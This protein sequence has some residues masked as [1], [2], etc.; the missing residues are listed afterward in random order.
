MLFAFVEEIYGLVVEFGSDSTR[1][2]FIGDDRPR[3]VIPSAYA[4]PSGRAGDLNLLG[5]GVE[6][7]VRVLEH[8]EIKDWEG[9]EFLWDEGVRRRL[10]LGLEDDLPP[11]ILVESPVLLS[12]SSRERLCQV[13]F[14]KFKVPALFMGKAPVLTVFESGRHTGLVVDI[15]AGSVSVTPVYDGYVLKNS[16]VVQRGFGSDWLREQLRMA[17]EIDLKID[18]EREL[19]AASEIRTKQPVG[20]TEPSNYELAADCDSLSASYLAYHRGR[21]LDELKESVVQ[22][23]EISFNVNDLALRPPK[24]FEFPTGYNRNFVLER[25]RIGELLFDPSKRYKASCDSVSSG[26]DSEPVGLTEMVSKCLSQ[27]DVDMRSNLVGNI[28]VCGGGSLLSGFSERVNTEFSKLSNYGRVR[29]HIG[30]STNERRFG[31]WIGG[32]ILGS[33]ASFQQLW[34]TRKE[35]EEL[36]PAAIERK[37]P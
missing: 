30:N 9:L 29:I 6:Q 14:E 11:L 3:V 35:F 28:I 31:S 16:A 15:G 27:C 13:A 4:L 18:M 17:L 36:G 22:V 5:R 1:I 8:G 32:S 21:V 19:R 10:G 33:L 24:Y 26:E 25:F 7:I 23:A 12:Q 20:L 37:F 2:G 34:M